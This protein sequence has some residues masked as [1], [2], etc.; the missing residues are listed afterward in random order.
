MLLGG[1]SVGRQSLLKRS[2]LS[3]KQSAP[4]T[5]DVPVSVWQTLPDEWHTAVARLLQ[6]VQES[7]DWPENAL[8]AYVVLIPKGQGTDIKMQR[9]ITVLELFY[10]IFAKGTVRTWRRT[11]MNEYLGEEAMG[12][13]TASGTRHLAQFLSDVVASRT[14]D[15]KEVWFAKFDIHKCYDSI[16]W[17][18]LWGVMSE[19][20]MPRKTVRAFR[21]FYEG[22]Q[23]P[24]SVW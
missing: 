10:R 23:T 1:D 6:Q 17:W 3:F 7:G 24:F 21:R 8:N 15:G 4:G 13:R 22:L 18:A 20:G 12:F 5:W 2:F 9:P 16:P 11:L 19:A 14:L